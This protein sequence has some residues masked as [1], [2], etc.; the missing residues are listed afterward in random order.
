[1]RKCYTDFVEFCYALE[2]GVFLFA[3]EPRA[4]I[5]FDGAVHQIAESVHM[6][7]HAI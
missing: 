7:L 1:M 3:R 4:V 6:I 5:D 2:N